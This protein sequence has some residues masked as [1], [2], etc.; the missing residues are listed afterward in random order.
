MKKDFKNGYIHKY[1]RDNE[2]FID[3]EKNQKSKSSKKY[4]YV[5]LV[6][7]DELEENGKKKSGENIYFKLRRRNE[8]AFF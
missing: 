5:N 2:H 8:S 7:E 3:Y 1:T 4:I 6:K